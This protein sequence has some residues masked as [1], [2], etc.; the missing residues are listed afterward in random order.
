MHAANNPR[1][2]PGTEPDIP[3]E[4]ARPDAHPIDRPPAHRPDARVA[5]PAR[6]SRGRQGRPP[7]R[8]V[9][10]RTRSARR[11]SRPRAP[12]CSSTTRSTGSPTRRWT[13]C[14][15]SPEAAGVEERRTAMFAGR[16][17]NTHRGPRG[18]PHRPPRCRAAEPLRV[19]G[20]D[21]GRR[22]PRGPRPDGGVRP[23]GPRRRVDGL[24]RQADPQRRQHRHRRQRPR[25]GDGDPGARPLQ[26]PLDAVPVR[27][28][29]RRHGHPRRD[30]GPRPRGDAVHRREQDVHHARDADQ[31]PDRARL[32]AGGP[33]GRRRRP[34]RSTSSPCPPTPSRSPAFGIDT[35]NMFGFWDW[36]GGRYSMDSAIG[37]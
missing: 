35:A 33:R 19:D 24:D 5:G 17:I 7:A 15:T 12:A 16:H 29:H 32:A 28:Q 8:P 22:R 26:R 20:Q 36:V 23:H 2:G 25:A 34:S 9:R 3:Q 10:G 21:V 18:P 30:R 4:Y 13:C 6:P 14:W 11:G 31:R 27:V 1:V 37:L